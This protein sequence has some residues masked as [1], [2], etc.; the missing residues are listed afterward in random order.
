MEATKPHTL[1]DDA[2][3]D[4]T[5]QEGSIINLKIVQKRK[6]MNNA[7]SLEWKRK[8]RE[9]I[10]QAGDRDK[11]KLKSLFKECFRPLGVCYDCKTCGNVVPANSRLG[12]LKRCVKK[13]QKQR[14]ALVKDL[15][16]SL[17]NKWY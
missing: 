2:L 10:R 9:I 16:T 5:S 1:E 7:K 8:R 3:T 17:D 14:E 12:H 11:H 6:S 13:T 4:D 15:L